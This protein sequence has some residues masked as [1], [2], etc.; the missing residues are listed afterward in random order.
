MVDTGRQLPSPS[1]SAWSI[2]L[3]AIDGPVFIVGRLAEQDA[4]AVLV[5]HLVEIGAVANTIAAERVV[6]NAP[7]TS[8]SVVW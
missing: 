2:D 4:R 3:A 5:L 8:V 7:I 1:A 6:A